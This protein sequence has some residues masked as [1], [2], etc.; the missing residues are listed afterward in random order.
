MFVNPFGIQLRTILLVLMLLVGLPVSASIT[1][2]DSRG[3]QVFSESPQRVVV[4]NWD[5]LEQVIELGV[6]PVG[7][8]NLPSYS[9]WVVQPAVPEGVEDIGTRAEPNFDKIAA[10]NPDVIIVASPQKDLIPA[11][12]RIAP[13]VY[14]SKFEQQDQAS[15]LAIEQFKKH[16]TLFEKEELA[17]KKLQAMDARFKELKGKLQ[18]VFGEQLP[19]VVT[20]RFASTTAVYLYGENS[21]TQYVQDKLGL[22]TALPQPAAQWGIIQKRL[23]ELQ[24]VKDG[25]VLYI[26]PFPHED[27]LN[28]SMLWKAMP[29]VRKGHVNSVRSVWSYG[30]AMSLLYTAEAITD[31]LLEVAPKP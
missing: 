11:L 18:A 14:I 19:E 22:T 2:Q 12:E 17:E 29:F 13:V 23:N 15:E 10:L 21:G 8:P 1:I 28:K 7:A 24:N 5:L 25:Y 27:K 9:E 16:A 3:E 26:L 6:T 30:G 20:L 4:L 31:A